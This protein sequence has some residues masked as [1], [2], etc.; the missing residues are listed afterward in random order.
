MKHILIFMLLIAPIFANEELEFENDF[1]S[2][3]DEVSEIATKTKLNIDDTPSFVSVL[4][5]EKLKRLGID[6]VFEALRLVPGVQ[7]KKEKT[8]VPIVIFRGVTQK[9]EVKLM[10]DGITINNSYRGSSYYYLDF[11]IEM[12]E[13]IEVIRGASS[14]LYGSGA[15]SG[16]INII[17][18]SSQHSS[19]NKVFVSGGTY[20]NY[21]SGAIVS[22]NIKNFKLTL[23]GYYQKSNKSIKSSDRH[24]KDYSLGINIKDEHF[25]FLARVKKS[26]IGN[27]YGVFGVIDEDRDKFNNENSSFFT[28]LS[29]KDNINKNNKINILAGYTNYKQIVQAVHPSLGLINTNYKENSY[30]SELS[31]ISTSLADNELLIG[32]KVES[33]KT[34]QSEWSTGLPYISD[35]NLDRKIYSLYLNNNYSFSSNFDISAGLRYDNYSDYGNSYSPNLGLVYRLTPEVRLKALYSHSFRAPSWIELTS[36]SSLEAETS[37]SL[38]MGIVFKANQNNILRFNLFASKI[39]DM[40][41]K[42]TAGQYV[43]NSENNFYGSEIEYIYSPNTKTELNFLASYIK[44]EDKD[45]NDLADVA[46]IL[47]STSLIY[48]LD[49][50]FTFG[51]LLQYVSSSKRSEVDSLETRD[52]MKDSLIFDQTISYAF[53]DFTASLIIK[54]L[55][56]AGTYYALPRNANGTD[57]DDGG[58]KFLIKASMEF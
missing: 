2:S 17:T 36:N 11:P 22:T 58:R 28:Q 48:E 42:D 29:Y 55:F 24:L 3:L 43:Q 32:A 40:I 26:D 33:S 49:S 47:A 46:N 9:G 52:K 51:S 45:G 38:E 37:D 44:A 4:H 31:L 6:S 53:K 12:I 14:I 56:D 5:S 1:L 30:F 18:K 19:K 15:I 25:E 23:D 50:H 34:L 54:D 41:A 27:A 16:V 10:V 35:P 21:K 7:L 39:E 57:F 20:D 8:G 13:R